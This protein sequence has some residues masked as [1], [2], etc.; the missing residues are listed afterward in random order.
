MKSRTRTN[1][2]KNNAKQQN[3]PKPKPAKKDKPFSAV[4]KHLGGFVGM[5]G[6]GKAV[7][8]IIGSI[9]GSGD[10]TTNFDGVNSNSLV[11]TTSV[12]EFG[13]YESTIITHREYISPVLTSSST[14]AFSITGYPIN[15][16]QGL[17][18]PWLAQIASNYEEY[19]FLGLVYEYKSNSG[20]ATTTSLAMPTVMLATEYDP[21]KPAFVNKAQMN[22]YFFSQSCRSDQCVMHAVECKSDLTP[23]K[24]LYTRTGGQVVGTDIRWSD[25]GNFYI[26]TYGGASPSASI[27]DLWVSYKVKLHKPRLPQTLEFGGQIASAHVYRTGVNT[28]NPLGTATGLSSGALN[29]TISGGVLSWPVLPAAKYLVCYTSPGVA[30]SG[31]SISASTSLTA[32]SVQQNGAA[33]TSQSWSGTTGLTTAITL[34][35]S[36]TDFATTGSITISGITFTG[37]TACDIF[38][39]QI[40]S[41]ITQ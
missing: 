33:Y 21:T 31:Y 39:A 9:L 12:P 3:K 19:E 26:A 29:L 7:G 38:V 24:R 4:G 1:K 18:F 40:D 13:T 28:A 17:S 30:S 25:Y 15:P 16:G 23:V 27:G 37:S 35:S 36:S 11:S 5:P 10:Y 22:N 2:Q 34:A 6:I 41:T 8:G 20:I 32:L 14:G